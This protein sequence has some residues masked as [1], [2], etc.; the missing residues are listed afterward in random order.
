M[1][2]PLL[3]ICVVVLALAGC[4]RQRSPHPVVPEPPVGKSTGTLTVDGRQRTYQLYRPATAHAGA[5]LVIVLH[6]AVGTGRQAEQAY[7]WDAEADKR[8][9]LVAYPD[10]VNRTWNAGPGCCGVA[11]RDNVD[12]V[13]FITRLAA[14]VPADPHRI[15]ATG[16]SNGAMLTYR[17]ACDTD[18]FAAIAP[19]AGTMIN[20][21]PAPKPLSIIH[22]HGDKD[23]TIPYA[24]GPGRRS[25][26]GTGRL[27]VKIDGPPV[28]ALIDTWRRTDNCAPPTTS[29][30]G[31]VTTSTATCPDGRAVELITIA[32]A[33]H[34]WPGSRPTPVAERLFH[35]DPPSTAL[36]ATPTI[37]QFF[38]AHPKS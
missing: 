31:P 13:A 35:L 21:C 10:G 3:V 6:G 27:P 18:I 30:A 22:I 9:F 14:A 36:A 5:P 11:A 8:G 20:D 7:G 4:T 17:L 1:K 37:W 25:N 26:D 38:N 24:G 28:P 12:D 19:V 15:Y 33:G 2:R 32:G 16:I 29:N 23:P 34:Q